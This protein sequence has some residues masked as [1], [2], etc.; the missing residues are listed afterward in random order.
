ML[1][2]TFFPRRHRRPTRRMACVGCLPAPGVCHIAL[3]ANPHVAFEQRGAGA[4]DH[5]A[6]RRWACTR[7]WSMR[8][9]SSPA[10]RELAALDLRACIEPL[11]AQ[12]VLPGGARP[13]AGPRGHARLVGA[14]A[15][16]AAGRG[17]AMRRAAGACQRQRPGAPVRRDAR[18]VRCCWPPT[19]PK[20]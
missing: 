10:P 13:A 8:P 12:R 18:C 11:S 5:H 14:P 20:A 9:T 3:V 19:S 16:P 4:P 1:A 17:A 7:W 6:W 15:R 2:C